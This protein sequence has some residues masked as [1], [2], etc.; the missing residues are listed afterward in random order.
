MLYYVGVGER[1][2]DVRR[3]MEARTMTLDEFRNDYDWKEAF[4]VAMRDNVRAAPSYAGS[5]ESFGVD[6]V[7]EILAISNGENDGPDWIGAFRLKD[8]RYAFVSAGC[9][10][11]GWGCQD[12]GCA[13]LADNV[14]DL[15]R[16]GMGDADRGR[17]GFTLS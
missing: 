13:R 8:G 5:T 4:A 3:G 1:D 6:D 16:L 7:E 10:Y 2:R 14:D 15:V 12:G 17:L 11:T 9:D